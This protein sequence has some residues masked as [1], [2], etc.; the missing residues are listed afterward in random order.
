LGFD[1][2]GRLTAKGEE[3]GA[4]LHLRICALLE[5]G[6]AGGAPQVATRN[7]CSR[8]HPRMSVV[9]H[10][11]KRG[12]TRVSTYAV[13]VCALGSCN[14]AANH[15]CEEGV[16]GV[17][18]RLVGNLVLHTLTSVA[19]LQSLKWP[20]LTLCSGCGLA[21]G[22]RRRAAVDASIYPLFWGT[23]RSPV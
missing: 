2:G 10:S 12:G 19:V 6:H 8:L 1:D 11:D 14:Q 5:L 9:T 23:N 20:E 18:S 17:G 13:L 21:P 7:H 22:T 16:V 3:S 15:G 4:R